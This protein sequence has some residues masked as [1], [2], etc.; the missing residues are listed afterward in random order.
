MLLAPRLGVGAVP[1]PPLCAC[2]GMSWGDFYLIGLV[3]VKAYVISSSR[4]RK[5]NISPN[6]WCH[7][8]RT[9]AHDVTLHETLVCGLETWIGKFLFL[10]IIYVMSVMFLSI[11]SIM[12]ETIEIWKL[13]NPA[14][15]LCGV[16]ICARGRAWLKR[17]L[18]TRCHAWLGA[19]HSVRGHTASGF[20]SWRRKSPISWCSFY[21]LSP[22]VGFIFAAPLGL[23]ITEELRPLPAQPPPATHSLTLKHR[24][25][26]THTHTH[27]KYNTRTHTHLIYVFSWRNIKEI[28]HVR[29]SFLYSET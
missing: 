26:H 19:I 6:P 21:Q 25:T 16:G 20:L 14:I 9:N 17:C 27:T 2:V 29:F 8:I 10:C 3:H 12:A 18:L 5:Q 22:H 23:N 11:K 7:L 15:Q 28:F 1:P 4:K 24:H 13:R